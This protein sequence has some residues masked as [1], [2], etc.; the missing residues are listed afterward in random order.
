MN[1]TSHSSVL[2]ALSHRASKFDRSRRGSHDN[3]RT[4]WS[5]DELDTL[6]NPNPDMD[7]NNGILQQEIREINSIQVPE[8]VLCIHGFAPPS[9]PKG[10]VRLIYENLNGLDTRMKDNDKVERMQ[11]LHDN[12][13][14]DIGAYCKH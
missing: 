4:P 14:A 12:L 7:S 11:E 2:Q 10:T 9:K 6:I 1:I 8:E 13:E 3:T 5:I